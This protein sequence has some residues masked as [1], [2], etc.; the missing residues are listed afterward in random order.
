[1]LIHSK[2]DTLLRFAAVALLAAAVSGCSAEPDIEIVEPAPE[3]MVLRLST[4]SSFSRADD[5]YDGKTDPYAEGE[6]AITRVSLFFFSEDPRLAGKAGEEPF[7]VHTVP[8]PLHAVTTADLTIKVPV[9]L[10]PSFV[11]K[12]AYVYALV[13]LSDISVDDAKKQI[14]GQSITYQKLQ[15]VWTTEDVFAAKGVPGTFVMRG[16]AMV[17][18]Q[19]EGDKLAWVKG[20]VMLERLASKIRL[21]A[22]IPPAIYL[23]EQGK[24][25]PYRYDENNR[26]ESEDAY[27]ERVKDI[28]A[29]KWEPVPTSGTDSN[30][31]LYLYNIATRGRIDAY[32]GS[33]EERDDAGSDPGGILRYRDV[34]RR[35]GC[36]EAVRLLVDHP[37]SLNVADISSDY[38]YTH[39]TAYYS[40]PNVWNS[41][42]P[43]EKHQTY[44][45][46]SMPWE[47]TASKNETGVEYQVCYYK[48]PV[49]ALVSGTDGAYADRLDPNRYY[50]IKIRLGML[51][52]KDLGDPLEIDASCEVADWTTSD[53]DV[54]IKPRRYLVVNQ[55]VWTMNNTSSIEI[56]FSSSHDVEVSECYVTYFRYNDIWGKDPDSVHSDNPTDQQHNSGE[57]D[58]WLS[59]A[60]SD[61][62]GK[63]IKD[64]E[65][66]IS[67][68]GLKWGETDQ[69]LR[70]TLYYKKEY[71]YDK[72]YAEDADLKANGNGG[73][74]YYVGHE[75]PKT[76][77]EPYITR[78]EGLSG[79]EKERWDEY[80]TTY[81]MNSIYTYRVDNETQLLTF[82]HPLI[83]WKEAYSDGKYYYVPE[84]KNGRLRSEYS[85]CEIT[86]KLRHIDRP[87]EEHLFEQTI[88]ITQYPGLYI[89]VS[90]DYGNPVP[91]SGSTE[92]GNRYVLVNG[93]TTEADR[94]G[95]WFNSTN[96][97]EVSSYMYY[98]GFI[99]NNP[100]MYVIHTT[101]LE[102]E[103]DG[104]YILGDPRNLYY[105]N[106]LGIDKTYEKTEDN[107]M[108]YTENVEAQGN[109]R[110]QWYQLRYSIVYGWV[111]DNLETIENATRLYDGSTGP[112]KYYY[113]TDE[114]EGAGSKESFVAPV[115]RIASSF[116]KVSLS[117]SYAQNI[118]RT[119]YLD[120]E[121]R[122]EARRR[123]AAYQEAGR[124]A[125]RWRVPTISEIEYVMQLSADN[126]I[127][128][129][130]GLINQSNSLYWCSTGLLSIDLVGI[131]DPNDGRTAR[132]RITER[133]GSYDIPQRN[134]PAV[135]CVY[136][137]WYWT[138]VDGGEFPVV[139][140]STSERLTPTTKTFYWG[141][142]PKD[143]PQTPD[144]P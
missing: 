108:V 40:Y 25:I 10:I 59:A 73:F 106:Q 97:N 113:P 136:D 124:P 46:L 70:Q 115:F 75:H 123:C 143:N 62:E 68:D 22:Q 83:W 33:T 100:N 76:F 7:Y 39:T 45:L 16:G 9:D 47:R 31:R 99:N 107:S 135:R 20:S 32:T 110:N 19:Q 82:D 50:R 121:S 30:V 112:L 139:N 17:S 133:D 1:M 35:P 54:N 48:I 127:P 71:F 111:F 52:S 11:N 5:E 90:H 67:L 98:F 6:E 4:G 138:Q 80:Q 116:G 129:L 120:R 140:R 24:T 105:N 78:P 65:G 89:E 137:E 132:D 91:T 109:N 44:V 29:E 55:P 72:Y 86:I 85:R 74:K 58:A 27:A 81:D 122:R 134:A 144:Q 88:H 34:D 101:Q 53:V 118:M 21:W 69:T 13:N 103:T 2:T 126:K 60:E 41:L 61:A 37:A 18:L 141:D 64:S 114:T 117:N 12:E 42:S 125:G 102:E 49:N 51:G 128:H 93:N 95:T 87:E 84:A 38:P 92:S 66:K 57:F 3:G 96:W 104:I 14:G 130:F 94:V 77:Q 63:N 142:R 26:R 43:T 56:P 8:G 23:D 119:N 36:E 15:E 28:A 131:D 79:D